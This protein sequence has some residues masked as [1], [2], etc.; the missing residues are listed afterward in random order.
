MKKIVLFF[1]ICFLFLSQINYVQGFESKTWCVSPNGSDDAKGTIEAP[2]QTLE[3][4]V[5]MMSY[6]DTLYLREGRYEEILTPKSNTTILAYPGEQPIITACEELTEWT[7][8]GNN[9]Y[10]T[11]MNWTL[12]HQNMILVDGEFAYEARWPD[13]EGSLLY[14]TMSTVTSIDPND[15]KRFA[16]TAIPDHINPI[17]ANVWICGGSRW[18]FW[19]RKVSAFDPITKM[20]TLDGAFN[21]NAANS[22]YDPKVTNPYVLMGKQEFLSCQN[23][24]Y[25]NANT[26]KLI[27]WSK[28]APSA[29][30]I[31]AKKRTEVLNLSGVTNTRIEG[32]SF[33]GG[34]IITDNNTSY[35][36]LHHIK[37]TYAAHSFSNSVQGHQI[38]GHHNLIENSEFAYASYTIIQDTGFYNRYLNNYI[39]DMNYHSNFIGSV[40]LAGSKAVFSHNTVCNG[41][42]ELLTLHNGKASLIQYNDLYHSSTLTWD[43]AATYVNMTDGD[44]T[45]IRYNTVHDTISS[46]LGMGI[47]FDPCVQNYIV[48]GNVIWNMTNSAIRTNN[49]ANYILLY[50][51]SAY[52]T[53]ALSTVCSGVRTEGDLY[54]TRYVNNI[55]DGAILSRF[56][57]NTVFQYNTLKSMT[58][59]PALWDYK[60]ETDPFAGTKLVSADF[61]DP[62]NGDFRLKKES[63]LLTS[64][65]P[66]PGVSEGA[67][68]GAY[69]SDATLFKTGHDFS[70]TYHEYYEFP[71]VLH[72]NRIRNAAFG[73]GD[74]RYW[75]TEGNNVSIKQDSSWSNA[76]ALTRAGN[77]SVKFGS[78]TNTISQKIKGLTKNTT[79]VL[80]GWVRT[81]GNSTVSMGIQELN[82][83]STFSEQKWTRKFITFNTGN[84][85][86][87]TVYYQSS[88]TGIS[89]CGDMGLAQSTLMPEETAKQVAKE[90]IQ[91]DMKPLLLSDQSRYGILI[92]D[93]VSFSEEQASVSLTSVTSQTLSAEIH[94]ISYKVKGNTK[95]MIQFTRHPV[96]LKAGSVSS[97]SHLTVPVPIPKETSLGKYQITIRATDGT[98]LNPIGSSFEYNYQVQ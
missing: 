34:R 53:G 50:N 42:R 15:R 66:I 8:L 81:D 19:V 85:T 33:T 5:S 10:E 60:M 68:I 94:V 70:K 54:G 35:C 13:N 27:I 21:N 63:A 78:G 65:T 82:I 14:P 9:L 7:S 1:L 93:G 36:T 95:E 48:Y 97:P 12:S 69:G 6:G 38:K 76:D 91:E 90:T 44:N 22:A 83:A 31:E 4:A 40:N 49:P 20:I 23:E 92:I 89:Y 18:I 74:L 55:F 51:N 47:Y 3:K 39:H 28:K 96:S 17:G 24:W 29:L 59:Y 57:N 98:L 67:H 64:G 61:R 41:G 52:R 79:Y 71:N 37:S 88:G 30:K 86:E 26:K 58:F 16:D 75:K 43:T 45:V 80:S 77:Y 87:I 72:M 32:I 11:S 84:K 73:Y 25:Y 56:P 62:E 46:H 2:F